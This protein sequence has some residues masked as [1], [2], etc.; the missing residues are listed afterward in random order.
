MSLLRGRIRLSTVLITLVFIVTLATYLL[1]RPV[2]ASI[3]GD[4]TPTS[5][6]ATRQPAATPTRAVVSPTPTAVTP[7]PSRTRSA[8]PVASISP[9]R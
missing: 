1:V 3:S 8:P 2:P 9:S 6:S 7:H 5:P 4:N